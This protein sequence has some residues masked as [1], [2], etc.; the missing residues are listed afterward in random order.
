MAD[1]LDVDV[2]GKSK[3]QVAQEMAMTILVNIEN[4]KFSEIK[5][6]DYL[7]AVYQSMRVLNLAWPP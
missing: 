6:L 3:Y 7:E 1:R 4:K 5:R 2:T